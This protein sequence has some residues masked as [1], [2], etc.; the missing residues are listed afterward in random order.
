MRER[1]TDSPARGEAHRRHRCVVGVVEL[2]L[3]RG[4][5]GNI[6]GNTSDD[7]TP[8]RYTF[9]PINFLSF[10]LDIDANMLLGV[11]LMYGSDFIIFGYC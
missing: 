4:H 8:A 1:E 5:G 2:S 11:I 7:K 9:Y 6:A 3:E 10:K